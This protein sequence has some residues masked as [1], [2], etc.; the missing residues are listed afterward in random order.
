MK[1]INIP[2]L[3][4]CGKKCAVLYCASAVNTKCF[5]QVEML[6]KKF[7][8]S[9]IYTRRTPLY[10]LTRCIREERTSLGTNIINV[11]KNAFDGPTVI[12]LINHWDY[13]A[14]TD[15]NPR[16]QKFPKISQDYNYIKGCNQDTSSRRDRLLKR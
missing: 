3:E 13:G 7:V 14:P 1:Y 10:T 11:P 2:Q 8:Y 5:G 6:T 16:R 9:D 4:G 12:H 15:M